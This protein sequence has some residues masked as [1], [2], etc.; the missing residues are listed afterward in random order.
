MTTST[1]STCLRLASSAWRRSCPPRAAIAEEDLELSLPSPSFSHGAQQGIGIG[2]KVIGHSGFPSAAVQSC[3]ARSL[4]K[5][6]VHGKVRAS[7][8][9][10]GSPRKPICGAFSLAPHE[11]EQPLRLVCIEMPC[12]GDPAGLRFRGLR[13]DV[14]IQS[15]SRGEQHVHGGLSRAVGFPPVSLALVVA[16]SESELVQPQLL[17]PEQ[18]GG[19]TCHGGRTGDGSRC[20]LRNPAAMSEEPTTLA[21]DRRQG[22]LRAWCGKTASRFLS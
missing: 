11:R 4:W 21:V 10:R 7:T 6:L 3:T 13:A 2:P 17:A 15:A 1:P 12:G 22:F 20:R 8:C 19:R 5:L 16:F 9:T 18:V 14:G